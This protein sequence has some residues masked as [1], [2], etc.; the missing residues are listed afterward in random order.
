MPALG[1]LR[2]V[3]DR[4]RL[5]GEIRHGAE[6]FCVLRVSLSVHGSRRLDSSGVMLLLSI[7]SRVS[8][9]QMFSVFQ[10]RRAV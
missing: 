9:T 4:A 2:R 6:P 5:I 7:L 8:V 1:E 3:I 10:A